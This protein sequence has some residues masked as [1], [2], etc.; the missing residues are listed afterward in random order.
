MKRELLRS[1]S[2]IAGK[3]LRLFILLSLLFACL[4]VVF[5]LI[6]F[7]SAKHALDDRFAEISNEVQAAFFQAQ[8][9]TEQSMLQVATLVANEPSVQR[10]FFAGKQALVGEQSAAATQ[11]ELQ[12]IRQ[13]LQG[14]LAMPWEVLARNYDF[15]QL[16][17]HF[18]PGSLSFLR[19]HEPERFGDRM[20]AVRHTVVTVNQ[21]HKSVSGI[22]TG[23]MHTGIR[24]VVPVFFS[25]SGA[26]GS[27]YVGALEAGTGFKTTLDNAV[28]G[29]KIEMA[30]LL[31]TRHLQEN[32]WPDILHSLCEKR[33]PRQGYYVEEATSPKIRE[34]LDSVNVAQLHPDLSWRIIDDFDPAILLIHIPLRDFAGQKDRDRDDIGKVMAWQP[35]AAELALFH[36]GVRTNILYAVFG[37]FITELLLYGALHVGISKLETMVEDGKRELAQTVDKLRHSE[38]KF[39]S[40]AEFSVDWDVWYGLDGQAIYIT[41]SCEEISGYPRELFYRDPDFFVSIVHPDDMEVFLRHRQDHY[42]KSTPPA[43]VTFRIIRKDGEVRWIWHKCQAVFA[44]DGEWQ[45][46]RTTNRDI[47][48]QKR[49]EAQLHRLSTTDSLTGAHNRRM[50]IDLL[51]RELQRS[52]RYGAIFS[53]LMFDIDYFKRVND[54]YGHDSGDRVLVEVVEVCRQTIRTTDTLARWGGEEFM[55]LLPLTESDEARSMGER[56]RKAIA[57]HDFADVDSLTVSVGVTSLRQLDTMDILLKRVDKALYAAKEAGR[58]RVVLL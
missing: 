20:D 54:R 53:L 36:K 55:V 21:T 1:G 18:G 34:I 29:R 19:V 15:R 38:R 23:R 4:D 6:N 22:E 25:G 49:I 39:K 52:R 56:L 2:R 41:P 32:I 44:D 43:E 5:V 17:F 46:R 30:V 11:Q 51:E 58:N 47:T 57:H 28:R 40:M 9:A 35:V 13:K 8:A 24:G 12:R 33:R 3:S 10:L 42:V 31:A 7:S 45:G 48:E 14:I 50:F 26:S 27:E 37:F 16:Q